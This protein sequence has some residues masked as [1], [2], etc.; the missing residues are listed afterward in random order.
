[1]IQTRHLIWLISGAPAFRPSS[2]QNQGL[3]S[4]L[5]AVESTLKHLNGGRLEIE[6]VVGG[7]AAAPL[8]ATVR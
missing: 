1:M 3:D 8:A 7:E 6:F 2:L 4:G 5:G